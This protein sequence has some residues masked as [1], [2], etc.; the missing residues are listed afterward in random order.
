M[1]LVGQQESHCHA[2][3]F[4]LVSSH[5]RPLFINARMVVV[6]LCGHQRQLTSGGRYSNDKRERLPL[7]LALPQNYSLLSDVKL[8]LPTFFLATAASY[9]VHLFNNFSPKIS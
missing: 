6:L 1:E 5:Y 8:S 9:C 3:M 7:M 4:G 2:E